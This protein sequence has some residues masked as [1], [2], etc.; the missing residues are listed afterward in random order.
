MLAGVLF[1][2][3][4]SVL[5]AVLCYYTVFLAPLD[6]Y[7]VFGWRVMGTVILVGLMISLLKEW[8][9]ISKQLI[10]IFKTPQ[11]LL[12]LLVCTALISLQLFLFAWAPLNQ[13]SEAL[14]MG[15]FLMPL[16]MVLCGRLIFQEQLSNYQKLAVTLAT[17]GVISNLVIHGNLSWVSMLVMLGYP[18][19]FILKRQL[20]LSAIHSMFIEHLLMLPIGILFVHAQNWSPDF[21]AVQQHGWLVIAG[22]GILGGVALLCFIAGSKLL[23]MSLFGM[24]GY[25]EPLLLF[26]VSLI[27]PGSRFSPIDF[28]TYVPIWLAICCLILN[29]WKSYQRTSPKAEYAA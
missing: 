27:L 25:L 10:K 23:P 8:R 20:G 3:T 4:A 2:M 12:I 1:C 14:A 16:S 29:G 7:E 21:F 19:Y 17:L 9:P 6:G 28:F 22:L 18:P 11:H 13:S 5:F 15:Y 24:L 26:V